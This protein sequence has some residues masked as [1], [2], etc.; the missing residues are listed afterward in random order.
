M[1]AVKR[2][3]Q[4]A[5]RF[6]PEPSAASFVGNR[7]TPTTNPVN[8]PIEHGP[9]NAPGADDD[10]GAVAVSVGAEAGGVSVGGDNRLAERVR[11]GTRRRQIARLAGAGQGQ[12]G[13]NVSEAG[14]GQPG[15]T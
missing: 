2:P 11:V 8:F 4:A 1:P 10:N 14:R 15:L 5:D 12:T 13:D 9:A 6:A 7:H 3:E